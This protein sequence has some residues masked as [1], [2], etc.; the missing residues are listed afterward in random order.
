LPFHVNREISGHK[1]A[2]IVFTSIDVNAKLSP[3]DFQ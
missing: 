1:D 3:A 2:E